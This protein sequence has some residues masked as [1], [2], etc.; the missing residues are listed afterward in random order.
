MKV[1]LIG[2]SGQA[3]S[4]IRALP[5][6]WELAAPPHRELA[7]EDTDTVRS[8]LADFRPDVVINACG[9]FDNVIGCESE[10]ERAFRANVVAMGAFCREL[11]D[12]GA[13]LVTFSTDYVFS[14]ARPTPYPE[15][16]LP[17]P[18][19]TYGIVRLA[20]EHMVRS[21]LE[22]DAMIL[23]T[24]GVYGA[25]GRTSRGGNF[26]DRRIAEVAQGGCIEVADDQFASPSYAVDLAAA[27]QSLVC[28]LPWQG[29]IYHLVNEGQV[30]WFEFTKMAC[31]GLGWGDRVR[32]VS[33]GGM[34]GTMRRPRNSA[35][36]NLRARA[37]G[38][39]LPTIEDAVHRYLA[40]NYAEKMV[41]A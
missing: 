38:I 33:R 26:L 25:A 31:A 3:G 6:N 27:V 10:P 32:P 18:I 23:R 24:C 41:A 21:V 13:R 39:V 17:H 20:E 16:E 36:A 14:G 22:D 12:C 1:L 2:G 35:L 7:I 37:R 29:G 4:E 40:A 11:R 34:D 9:G 30:S 19:N 28:E 8:V 15:D 5:A